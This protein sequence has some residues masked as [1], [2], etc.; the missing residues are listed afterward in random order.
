MALSIDDIPAEFFI[1]VAIGVRSLAA[2]CEEFA[3]PETFV[4]ASEADPAFIRRLRQAEQAVLDNGSAFRARCR[5]VVNDS[6]RDMERLIRD[7]ETP[8]S[9]QLEAFK[10]L[11]KFG[12]LEPVKQAATGPQGPV[13]TLTIVAPGG[14]TQVTAFA[15]QPPSPALP[16]GLDSDIEG[17][18][19]EVPAITQAQPAMS[20]PHDDAES[21]LFGAE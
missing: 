1:A 12:D 19:V 16:S 9:T 15:A 20:H 13:L 14:A 7:P 2:I 3:I 11:A 17:E 4:Q 18:V 21:S 10:T 8:A 5:L 6:I